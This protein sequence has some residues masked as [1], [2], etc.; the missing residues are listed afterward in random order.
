MHESF[1]LMATTAA[2]VPDVRLQTFPHCQK[3]GARSPPV[4]SRR[5]RPPRPQK[6]HSH[7]R[8]CR[9]QTYYKPV[10][11]HLRQHWGFIWSQGLVVAARYYSVAPGSVSHCWV[12]GRPPAF[13]FIASQ[14]ERVP[15]CHVA[16]TPIARRRSIMTSSWEIASYLIARVS[17]LKR[18][19]VV[20]QK[21][22][23]FSPVR[24]ELLRFKLN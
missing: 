10:T 20:T 14:Q 11:S 12:R 18:R 2:G 22:S 6:T 1:L 21:T 16:R 13:W 9:S 23:N 5:L 7:L 24:N 19:Q 15:V 4:T 3:I 17:I 8:L